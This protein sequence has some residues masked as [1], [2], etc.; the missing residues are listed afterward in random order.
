MDEIAST[1]AKDGLPDG[2][3]KAAGE[4]YQRTAYF[5][6]ATE[7]PELVDVLKSLTQNK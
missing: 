2:L 1:F 7:I 4:V 6:D 3:H 5:K